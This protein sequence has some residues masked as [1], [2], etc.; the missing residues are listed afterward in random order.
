MGWL[1]TW[2][3]RHGPIIIDHTKLDDDET[4]TDFP[5]RIHIS[6]SSGINNVDLTEIFTEIADADRKKIA[7]TSADGTTQLFVEIEI[8][9]QANKEAELWVK[10]PSINPKQDLLLFLYYD[11]NQS[12]NT[13]FVG[14]TNSTLAET[15]WDSNYKG[16]WHM[17]QDPSGS[18]PQLLDS[19]SN[20]NDGTSLGS[21]TSADLV[22]GK[23][24]KAIEHDNVDDG[25]TIPNT[26]NIFDLTTSWTIEACVKAFNAT[27]LGGAANPIIFKIANDGL[28][29]ETFNMRYLAESRYA[30]GLER[31][32]DDV[33]L[34]AFSLT[35]IHNEWYHIVGVY[36]GT[37]LKIYVNGVLED[38]NNIG[39]VIAYTGPA[40]LKIGNILNSN[41]DGKG[42]FDGIID[43]V[44]ILDVGKS[45][46]YAKANFHN[47]FDNLLRFNVPSSNLGQLKKAKVKVFR[48]FS[49]RRRLDDGSGDYETNWQDL[50]NHVIRWGSLESSIDDKKFNFVTQ[51]GLTLTLDNTEGTFDQ[52]Q[53]SASFWKAA[54]TRYRTL[55]KIEAG[56]VDPD[57]GT[58]IP[59]P[60]VLF[61]GILSQENINQ[62]DDFKVTFN[63]KSLISVLD[64]VDA[65]KILT[66]TDLP[67]L[68]ICDNISDKI[69]NTTVNGS[70]LSSFPITDYDASATTPAGISHAT[71]NTLW[72]TDTI[73]GKIYNVQPAGTLSSSFLSTVYDA[74]GGTPR[75]ISYA[76]DDTIWVF[77][78]GPSPDTV[79]NVQTNGTLI[80]SFEVTTKITTTAIIQGL[81]A[82]DDGTLWLADINLSGVSKIWHVESD[83]TIITGFNT[84]LYDEAATS[85]RGISIDPSGELWITDST[86]KKIYNVK[87]TGELIK[88]FTSG[89]YDVNSTSP[90][91]VSYSHNF[92]KSS[93]LVTKIKNVT[94]GASNLILQKFISATAWNI[95]L[96]TNTLTA[97]TSTSQF[98]NLSCW[99]LA[100]KLA[101]IEQKVAYINKDGEFQFVNRDVLTT[102]ASFIFVGIPFRDSNYGHTIKRLNN[103]R[104][105][106]DLL[107]NKVT[108]KFGNTNTA[109]IT[110]SESWIVGDSSTSWVYGV[111]PLTINNTWIKSIT[112]EKIASDTFVDLNKINIKTD[113]ITKFIPHLKVLDRIEV[114]YDPD[115]SITGTKWDLFNWD[116]ANW[117]T[118]SSP[119]FGF[120]GRQFK[121]IKMRHNLDNFESTFT[122]REV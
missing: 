100:G 103:Y 56:F 4:L 29:E 69:Y 1:G 36:D 16:V 99:Q 11:S 60:S 23:V 110:K 22:D 88:S 12:D 2:A 30:I 64:E 42:V 25:F 95:S 84:S 41:F 21:M 15:V 92:Q 18:A 107:H 39:S 111:R 105:D 26:G 81:S 40:P 13:S 87:Q 31:A 65:N 3:N 118:E 89:A 73:E 83:G 38:T 50:S 72:I 5:L 90:R 34:S 119:F 17:S 114:K 14:D 6:T 70:L 67:T 35:H 46:S 28:N 82:A 106:I 76:P 97:L 93:D 85:P 20:N 122:I 62:S 80:S 33:D 63:V 47:L 77:D 75:G 104:D 101:E 108:V 53:S 96:T 109:Q 48:R 52:E 112:A 94:D 121:I 113:I 79:F 9:D 68:W 86:T 91:G 117:A 51:R 10:I 120:A 102:T 54:I 55:V 115:A 74:S 59:N 57:D 45:A 24:G 78:A 27:S 8:W 19:T 98:D 58:D 44:L 66:T 116:E 71:D 61:Y 32:S 37:D 7:V 49:V 43:N